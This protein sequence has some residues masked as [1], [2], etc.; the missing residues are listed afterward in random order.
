VLLLVKHS[1]PAIDPAVPPAEW[2][3][4]EEGKAR[5]EHLALRLREFD[6]AA[7]VS[8]TEPKAAET[9]AALSVEVTFDE[10]LREPDRSGVP[11]LGEAEFGRAVGAAFERPDEIVF[12][13]ESIAA[14]RNR[15]AASVE[16][17]R[18]HVSGTLVVVAH[19]T[20]IAAY[21]AAQA[22][23][24]GFALWRRLGLPSFVVLDGTELID[25]VEEI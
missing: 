1:L 5:C 21:A 7:I 8:S 24:D 19:G 13:R 11:W 4:S 17:H 12:G 23:V 20:V 2:P 22:G 18:R 6:P 3:L 15:F 10:R 16:D 9:A 25:V 14:A